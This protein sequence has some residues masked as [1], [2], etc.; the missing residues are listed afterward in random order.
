MTGTGSPEELVARTRPLPGPVDL[1]GI[2]SGA[3]GVLW[4]N[5]ELGLAGAGTALRL[6]FAGPADGPAVA[7]A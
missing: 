2:G 4:M 6:G 3:N 1:I 7:R 5:E